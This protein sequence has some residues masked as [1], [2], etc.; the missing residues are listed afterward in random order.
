MF[1]VIKLWD[2]N[3]I[4]LAKSYVHFYYKYS[5]TCKNTKEFTAKPYRC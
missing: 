5:Q 2:K 3:N 4:T 1:K